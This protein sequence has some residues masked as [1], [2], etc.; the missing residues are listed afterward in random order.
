[1]QA[2]NTI[3]SPS[4]FSLE[5]LESRRLLS[6]SLH[7][8]SSL[9]AAPSFDLHPNVTSTTP[10]G[11]TPQQIRHAYGF[12][13]ITFN[14][15]AVIGDGK[16]QTIAIVDAYDDPNITSDLAKF[17]TQ[18]SLPQMTG[19]NGNPSF[20]KVKQA[21]RISGNSGW[22]LEIALDVEWAHAVAPLANI[23]LVE[24]KTA[25]ISNLLS[26]V[27]VARKRTG[28]GAV[29][30]SWGAGEFST[31][32]S[33]DTYFTTPSNH[34]NVTFVSS[35]GDD[36]A[37]VEW[38]AISSNVVSV[39]GTTL[40]LD[41]SGNILS[42]SAWSGSGGGVS[43]Y[44]AKPSYQSGLSFTRRSNPDISYDANP[45]TGFPVYDTVSYGGTT[46]WFEV[47]GTSAG[48]PQ[49]AALIA[50]A[51][52]GRTLAG[53]G[54][55]DSRTQTLPMLYASAGTS[56]NFHDIT[57]GASTGSPSYS[58]TIGYDLATGPGSPISNSLVQQLLA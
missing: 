54:T 19:T 20:T 47:G 28:V 5:T 14:N 34:N 26:S 29:S 58:A 41:S 7:A 2:R 44:I 53:K 3:G 45:S 48:S 12:D 11:Y 27:D 36:G 42:E 35:S 56:A 8:L 15:G 18:Y 30:M 33:Y 39:G 49:I 50:I 25:S 24:A 31:E 55:L 13:G 9:S 16:G 46:G 37:P 40:N 57:T 10:H 1:M 17:S 21:S 23:V 4:G 52:Q 6:A 22:S 51:D 32:S 43:A 38:P